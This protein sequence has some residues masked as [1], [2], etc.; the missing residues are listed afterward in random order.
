MVETRSP[1]VKMTDDYLTANSPQAGDD[2]PSVRR[3][4]NCPSEEMLASYL[5]G[6]MGSEGRGRIES[7]L[8]DCEYCRSLVADV[9]RLQRFDAAP[10]PLD[11]TQKAIALVAPKSRRPRWILWPAAAMAGTAFVVIATFML[12]SPQQLIVPSPSAP[13]APVIAK[14]EPAPTVRRPDRDIVRKLAPTS[15]S[16]I[17]IFPKRDS[18]VAREQLEFKWKP[19][20]RSRYYDIH[21][22]TSDGDMVWA[23]QSDRVVL[24]LPGDLT[25][26][27]GPYFVWISAY[28]DDGRVQKSAP[29]RFL[30]TASR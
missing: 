27:D 4:W 21:V 29:V 18:V 11:L 12:R 30:V 8:V 10:L 22:V 19:V 28:L 16:P 3:R 5:D 14:S 26:K 7:H 2:G 23:G 20:P 15:L 13:A 1:G 9:V 6:A 24:K 17:L 25:L